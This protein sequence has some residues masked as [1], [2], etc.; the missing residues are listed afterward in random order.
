MSRYNVFLGDPHEETRIGIESAVRTYAKLL[1]FI[2][3]YV[4]S[5]FPSL[6]LGLIY[7]KSVGICIGY[8]PTT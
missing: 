2:V 3:F 7:R 8:R 6:A 4:A 5:V 1:F